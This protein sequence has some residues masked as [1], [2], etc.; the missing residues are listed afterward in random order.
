MN[1]SK[2]KTSRGGPTLFS[3]SPPGA[4]LPSYSEDLRKIS[5][6]WMKGNAAVLK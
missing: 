5:G 6:S 4:L 2:V 3:V 1:K